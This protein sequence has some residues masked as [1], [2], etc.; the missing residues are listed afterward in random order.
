M[1]GQWR[2]DSAANAWSG[3]DGAGLLDLD[4]NTYMLGGWNPAWPG[5]DTCSEVWMRPRGRS[6][7]QRLADAPWAPRHTAV[8]LVHDG[9]V[10]VLGGDTLGSYYQKDVWCGTPFQGGV[11]WRCVDAVAPWADPGRVLHVGYSFDGRIVIMGG[12]TLDEFVGAT[13]RAN[14]PSPYY[15][16]VWTWKDGCGWQQVADDQPWAPCGMVMGGPIKDGHMWLIGGGCYDT[17]GNPRIYKNS[18]WK[19][20]N[21][22]DWKCVT[23]AAAFPPRQFN[24]AEVLGDKLVLFAG[25]SGVNMKDLW[26]SSDGETWTEHKGAPVAERHAASMC[27]VNGEL[28]MLGGPLNESAV[29]AVG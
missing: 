27:R 4:G 3:R 9:K 24:N 21:A 16:D 6:T 13:G 25:W 19:S 18:V 20:C 5:T 8:W 15:R 29:Y 17:A 11:R 26:S 7:W 22:T 10:W 14:L 23:P 12:Q 2:K 28:L 1:F